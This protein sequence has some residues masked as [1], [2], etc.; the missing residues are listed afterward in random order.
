VKRA[1]LL[2]AALLAQ[3]GSA[4][5]LELSASPALL[6]ADDGARHFAARWKASVTSGGQVTLASSFARERWWEF[7]GRGTVT[8][9]HATSE[10]LFEGTF[11]PGL[12]VLLSRQ[13]PCNPDCPP[14]DFDLGYLVVT[15]V[16]EAE[17]GQAAEEAHGGVGAAMLY[18]HLHQHALWPVIPSVSVAFQLARPLRSER[19]DLVGV[20]KDWYRRLDLELIWSLRFDRSWV[21]GFLRPLRADLDLLHFREYGL[22]APEA[23]L[24]DDSGTFTAADLG[25]ELTGLV[26]VVR[27]VFVRRT[28]G[29]RVTSPLNGKTWMVGVVLGPR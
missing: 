10:P 27:Q 6:R 26:P 24:A 7:D 21:P 28:E 16:A 25:Y 9:R 11:S 2:L 8:A 22:D 1:L 20:D 23:V 19:L 18:R 4:Q 5:E 13:R 3:P 17:V 29:E 12:R 15:A 14:P